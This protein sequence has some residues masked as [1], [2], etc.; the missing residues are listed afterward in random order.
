MRA[1]RFCFLPILSSL[2]L[3]PGSSSV[4][5]QSN[6]GSRIIAVVVSDRSQ[7]AFESAVE[8]AENAG[9]RVMHLFPPDVF[10]ASF[11]AGPNRA[12][13]AEFN[14]TLADVPEAVAGKGLDLV[15]E[16]AVR[17]LL[18]ERRADF[19]DSSSSLEGP[20]ED[21][22]LRLPPEV[23]RATTPPGPRMGSTR[24]L[25]DRGPMQ[26]SEFMLGKVLVN[27]IFPESSGG[28][29][30]WTEEEI[31]N[32]VADMAL[33]LQQYLQRAS[34]TELSFTYN[35]RNF[36]RVP[37]SM[38][39]I[40]SNMGTDYM[41]IGEA[42]QNLGYSGGAYYAPHL[43]N[44]STR[45][46]F[47]TDWVFTAFVAD[48]SAH[49]DPNAPRPDPGCWG[50]AGY[51]AYAYLG[52][53][54][55]VV[56]YPACRYGYG[57]GFGR[58][59]IHEM[60]HIFWALDEYESAETPCTERSGYLNVPTLNTLYKPEVCHSTPVECIMQTASPPFEAPLP[61]CE[62]TQGQV[63]LSSTDIG[64]ITV[65][66]IYATYPKIEFLS[67]PSVPVDTILPGDDYMLYAVITNPAVPNLNPQQD[68]DFRTDYAPSLRSGEISINVSP[69]EPVAPSTGAWDSAREDLGMEIP[70]SK[71][72]PGLNKLNLR[73]RN[74]VGL[75][76][77]ATRDIYLIGLKYFFVSARALPD[78][79]DISW[80]TP[81]EVFGAGF[82]IIRT[83]ETIREKERVVG[84]VTEPSVR[85]SDRNEYVFVDTLVSAGH[86][87]SYRIVGSFGIYFRG[88]HRD[89]S[90]SSSD[91]SVTAPVPIAEGNFVSNLL[92][93]PS[94]GCMSFSIDVP[95]TKKDAED[96]REL[97]AV[98]DASPSSAAVLVRT[99][100]EVMIYDVSGR[101][102]RTIY[103]GSRFG[104]LVS[105]NWDGR[106][107]SGTMVPPG[108]YFLSVKAGLLKDVRKIVILR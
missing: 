96:S 55:L 79:I 27:I 24:E 58:V 46:V 97:F 107:D 104:G 34:W 33:G 108:I 61:I 106:D 94:N 92:P 65:P 53:P 41:W 78:R 86:R 85:G 54:Y 90:I 72:Q 28:S 84:S 95:E 62:T 50:G 81:S 103:V 44:N 105:M 26:N 12:M 89:F 49:Y 80:A 71:F 91:F 21:I 51:V 88:Q 99:P 93:N 4:A 23:V 101:R 40:E 59:F 30:D 98:G 9:A 10:V 39:P 15:T 25:L 8:K 57:L 3:F 6:D 16:K 31:A 5:A 19:Y 73:I 32:A 1:L 68:P 13:F 29:E 2:A 100:L 69:F 45:N 102:I 22:V 43:L 64:P 83:D 47:K 75:E 74:R 60:S 35:Y 20:I 14:V 82:E 87:Y 17:A 37:V 18:G 52:G 42:M 7:V 66:T 38:E 11:P 67:F 76:T 63:G 48:M 70:G 36:I 77:I 56:P